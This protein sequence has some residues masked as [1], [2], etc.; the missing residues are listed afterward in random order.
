MNLVKRFSAWWE[1]P[2]KDF[3]DPLWA[4]YLGVAVLKAL[5]RN[6]RKHLGYVPVAD[7]IAPLAKTL[8]RDGIVLIENFLSASVF[9]EIRAE[10]EKERARVPL[11]PHASPY[12][13][14]LG[15]EK[16]RVSV[17]HL[18]PEPGT[19]LYTLL[20]AHFIKSDTLTR[21]GSTVARERITA[22]R[23]PQIFVNKKEGDEY[24]DL[25]SD[26]YYHADVTYPGVKAFLYLSDT[27]TDN[28]AFT[29]AKGTHRLSWKRLKWNYWKSIEH[30]KNRAG[31]AEGD[32]DGRAWHC[33]TRAEEQREG[34]VGTSMVGPANSV[35]MFNV[36]GFHRRGEFTSDRPREFV[37]AYYRT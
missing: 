17:G 3:E 34:I 28:G 31:G 15:H 19:R 11:R 20:D 4:N 1:R 21:L 2:P 25:N 23:P 36:M 14:K 32:V 30:A 26:I 7:D 18:I 13:R 29:Y 16:L 12:I 33:M 9:A 22:F 35:V 24:P 5:Y 6:A 10:Y 27:G 37:L 8:E